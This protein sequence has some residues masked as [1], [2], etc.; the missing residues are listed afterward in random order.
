MTCSPNKE[1]QYVT[2]VLLNVVLSPFCLVN[3]VLLSM[4]G[5]GIKTVLDALPHV[6]RLCRS[7]PLCVA[8]GLHASCNN[9]NEVSQ[10]GQCWKYDHH[11]A[12]P[13]YQPI[14]NKIP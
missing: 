3:T 10:P 5:R 4:E 12:K 6:I 7:L 14:L 13:S 1:D 2:Q 8:A 11:K 9:S